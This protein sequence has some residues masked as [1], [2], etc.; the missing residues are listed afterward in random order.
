MAKRTSKDPAERRQEFLD[1]A[2]H[3]FLTKGYEN[4]SISDIVEA[5]GVAHGLFYYYFRSKDEIVD[6]IVSR[7]LSVFE[8]RLS[9]IVAIDELN[10]LEK[11]RRMYLASYEFKK[12]RSGFITYVNAQEQHMLLRSSLRKRVYEHILPSFAQIVRQGNEEGVFDVA[13][14]EETAHVIF[15]LSDLFDMESEQF[16]AEALKRQFYAILDIMEHLLGTEKGTLLAL[17]DDM[18]QNLDGLMEE[19]VDQYRLQKDDANREV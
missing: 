17:F 18:V 1:A 16:D 10:S 8:E 7:N 5:V 19:A 6:G 14:P 2:E 3:L 12:G 15:S 4:T 9:S 13:Y 11:M